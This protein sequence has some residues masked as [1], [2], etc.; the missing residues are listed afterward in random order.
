MVSGGL[1]HTCAL[2]DTGVLCWGDDNSG[3]STVPTLINPVAVSVGY[4]YTCVLDD[5]GVTCWGDDA[6]GQ[7]TV[8]ALVFDKDL[9]GLLDSQ[10]DANGNGLVDAGETNSLDTDSDADGLSDGYELFRRCKLF[11]V[12]AT[13]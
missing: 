2:D 10:E 12:T 7:S 1:N 3:Q 4:F 6:N 11:C 9:D 8:P 5:R 13:G